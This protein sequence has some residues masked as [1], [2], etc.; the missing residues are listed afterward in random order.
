MSEYPE[1]V[2]VDEQQ[3]VMPVTHQR[4][5]VIMAVLGVLGSIAGFVFI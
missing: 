2:A 3:P 5:L 1:P 4:I